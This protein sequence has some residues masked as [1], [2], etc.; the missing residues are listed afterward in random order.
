MSIETKTC[1]Y[2]H[3][4]LSAKGEFYCSTKCKKET[5]RILEFWNNYNKPEFGTGG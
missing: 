4:P 5:D 2:C 3:T 1:I